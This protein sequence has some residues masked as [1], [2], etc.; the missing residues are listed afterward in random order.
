MTEKERRRRRCSPL[1]REIKN[2]TGK[3]QGEILKNEPFCSRLDILMW[4]LSSFPLLFSLV[5]RPLRL[6]TTRAFGINDCVSDL[7]QRLKQ[8]HSRSFQDFFFLLTLS[9]L[10]ETRPDS[11][12]MKDPSRQTCRQREREKGIDNETGKK[13]E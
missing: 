9:R 7:L 10:Q 1:Y 11:I 5:L 12:K 3:I 6:G 2:K 13:V 8:D 4:Q